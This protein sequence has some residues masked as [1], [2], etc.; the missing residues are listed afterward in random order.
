LIF[1]LALIPALAS[2]WPAQGAPYPLTN[3]LGEKVTI[4]ARGLYYWDTLSM[5]AQTQGND[6]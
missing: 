3:F 6:L 4:N 1:V 5:A 2:I